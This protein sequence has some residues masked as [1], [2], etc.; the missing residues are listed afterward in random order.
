[1]RR[2]KFLIP[3]LGV[4]LIVPL[5]LGFIQSAQAAESDN[6]MIELHKLAFTDDEDHVIKNTGE[7]LNDLQGGTPLSGITFD[8]YDVTEAFYKEY[9]TGETAET[10]QSN[11]SE[12]AKIYETAEALKGTVATNDAGIASFSLPKKSG[13]RDAVYLFAEEQPADTATAHIE[14]GDPFV[15]SLPVY[16]NNVE[17]STIMV[18][19]KNKIKQVSPAVD[20]KHFVKVDKDNENKT[21]A[22]AQF[23]FINDAGEYLVKRADEDYGWDNDPDPSSL[24]IKTSDKKGAFSIVNLACGKYSVKEIKAPDGYIL[25]DQLIPFTVEEGS[26]DAAAPVLKIENTKKTRAHGSATPGSKNLPKT[27]EV[28]ASTLPLIGL[29]IIAVILGCFCRRKTAERND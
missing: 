9:A 7:Q 1:M 23:I 17:L 10:I 29:L 26:G 25:S 20:G 22:G 8:V 6:V 11:I 3:L 16:V 21:L 15:I 27:G 18:Y 24:V 28:R 12:N 13:S 2:R 14:A 19:P 5:F 4:L